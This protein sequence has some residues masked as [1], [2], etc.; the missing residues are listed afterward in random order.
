MPIIPAQLL[1]LCLVSLALTAC[2]S[3]DSSKPTNEQSQA[4]KEL[5]AILSPEQQA[6]ERTL[7]E[8]DALTAPYIAL[9]TKLLDLGG[10]DPATLASIED[11]DNRLNMINQLMEF[12]AYILEQYPVLFNTLQGAY[13]PQGIRQ[14]K[15]VQDIRALNTEIYPHMGSSLLIVKQHWS[16]SGNASDDRFY[17]GDNVP[18]EA[19]EQFNAHL[20][21]VDSLSQQQA[22]LMDAFD[23]ASKA[24]PDQPE[25]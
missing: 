3:K 14:L 2:G 11:I 8:I 7:L 19:V 22:N 1:L 4:S 21:A 12:N 9:N 18:K 23:A 15:L 25:P 5:S 17:F 16:T 13:S 6:H 24:D 20:T 10:I